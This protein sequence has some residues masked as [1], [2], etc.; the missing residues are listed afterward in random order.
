MLD[1]LIIPYSDIFLH[2]HKFSALYCIDTVGGNSV[3][4]SREK[5]A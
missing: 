5:K 2:S 4:V 3:L 1:H